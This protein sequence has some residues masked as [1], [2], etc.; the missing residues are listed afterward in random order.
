MKEI[1]N[2]DMK[3]SKVDSDISMYK[4][5]LLAVGVYSDGGK[6]DKLA[7][8]L[9]KSLG[10]AI[11]RLVKLG[12]FKG[13][14]KTSAMLYGEDNIAATRVLLVGLG[15]KKKLTTDGIRKA[16]AIAAN[17]AVQLKAKKL[18]IAIHHAL[19]A[20]FDTADTA[21][22][23]AQGAYSGG[24]RYDEYVSDDEE[25]G[26]L[27]S[28]QIEIIDS[29]WNRI[30]KLR[31]G[32]AVGAV[33]GESQN[34]ART[35]ANRPGNVINP[36]KMAQEAKKLARGS[37][38]LTCT[39]FDDKQIAANGMGG[40]EAIGSG[41]KNK[42]RFIVLKYTPTSK[43]AAKLPTVAIIGKAITFDSGGISIKPSN[44]MEQMKLDKSGGTTVLGVI[45]AVD[46]LQL[47][48]NIYAI[49]PSAENMP[50]ASSCRPGDIVKTFSGKTVEIQNTDAE[51][52]MILCDAI[53]YA[54]KQKC[55]IIVDIA[56]L[57]GACMVALGKS[58]AGLMGNDA[59]LIKQLEKAS[60]KSG[61]K[62]WHLPSGEE[63]LKDMKSKIADLKNIGG[64]WGGA[65]TAAAFL[66]E[67]ADDKKW[68]HIDMAGVDLFEKASVL[69]TEGSTGFGV[70]LLVEF[71]AS[72]S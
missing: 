1:I 70:R 9:D 19:A 63:Y 28:V 30:K 71:L 67:F 6:L 26:R 58:R 47:P 48:L 24:Y 52:R 69:S 61:E 31:K 66:G 60:E 72:V 56:T 54:V 44:G 13:K 25:N 29:D 65:C 32:L 36:E 62:I 38:T 34:Y 27:E 59:K 68:A 39:V 35:I 12:D 15:E 22:I 49:I 37:K 51:G 46:K 17:K 8:E 16:A 41:S 10:G 43:K 57:T 33:I 2:I 4:T 53:A 20:K 21:A 23:I 50:S 45:K 11:E 14:P 64:R 7:A 42:P 40:I 5:D 18:S 3:V 55:D